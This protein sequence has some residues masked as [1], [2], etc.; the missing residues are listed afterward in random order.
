M[1]TEAASIDELTLSADE[2]HAAEAFVVDVDGFEGPLHLLLDLARRQKVDLLHVSVLELARQYLRFVEDAKSKRIDLAAD[3]LLMASWLAYLKSKLL[4]PKPQA[5]ADDD[6]SGEDMAAR[7]A[8]RLKRLDAMRDAAET[9]Q[10]GP[11]LNNVVFLRGAPEQPKVL[12]RT[13]Y[14][15]SLW[16][17]MQALG[18]IRG[19]KEKDAPHRVEKQFV[20]PLEAARDSLRHVIPDLSEWETL[21]EIRARLRPQTTNLPDRSVAASVFSAALEL[22]RDGDVDVRQAAHFADLYLRNAS[23][24]KEGAVA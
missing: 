6:I 4:L 10:S 24:H 16:H 20:L 9:L 22:A 18:A 14:D 2:A 11:V 23:Q 17:I 1:N 7:L 5:P 3:Y 21:D 15:T 8:F 12:K 19:R 13:E